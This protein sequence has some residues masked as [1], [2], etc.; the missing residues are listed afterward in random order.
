MDLVKQLSDSLTHLNWETDCTYHTIAGSGMNDLVASI[1]NLK[2]FNIVCKSYSSRTYLP[3]DAIFPF[4]P[5][6][7][8]RLE[9]FK[10]R[11]QIQ[12]HFSKKYV[13]LMSNAP[14][15]QF[16]K[17]LDLNAQVM[18]I[19]YLKYITEKFKMVETLSVQ[20]SNVLTVGSSKKVSKEAVETIIQDFCKYCKE[21]KGAVKVDLFIEGREE[22]F[23]IS[24]N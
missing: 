19:W 20:I 11:G 14:I 24:H 12:Y 9:E 5:F 17:S 18:D 23:Q 13:G 7:H 16:L 4:V 22:R 15:N 2:S 3:K 1:G 6:P 21:I 8:A 10:I